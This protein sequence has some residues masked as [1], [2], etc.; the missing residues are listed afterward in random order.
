M[1]FKDIIYMNLYFKRILFFFHIEFITVFYF[2]IKRS[3]PKKMGFYFTLFKIQNGIESNIILNR[4][5]IFFFF[6]DN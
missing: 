4:L 5:E 3:I 6:F 1:N 2:P